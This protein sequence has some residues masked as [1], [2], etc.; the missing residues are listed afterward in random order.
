MLRT[1][2][3]FLPLARKRGTPKRLH[4]AMWDAIGLARNLRP[5]PLLPYVFVRQAED[6]HE[7]C[8]LG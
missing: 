3:I 7:T 2:G 6:Q 4:G 8:W 1:Q 5:K